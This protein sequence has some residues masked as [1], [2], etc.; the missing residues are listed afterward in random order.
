M[1]NTK[2]LHGYAYNAAGTPLTGLT[3]NVYRVDTG[4]LVASTTTLAENLPDYGAG[5][6]RV[7]NLA[8]EYR[9]RAEIVLNGSQKL[10]RHDWSGEVDHLT[11]AEALYMPARESVYLNGTLIGSTFLPLT[12]GTISGPVTI[13]SNLA[14]S[15]SVTAGG[16]AVIH[17]GNIGSQ[18][19]NYAATAGNADTVD[20][21]HASA[22][23]L[24]GHSHNNVVFFE[25]LG[26]G[27]A[28]WVDTGLGA[29]PR[30]VKIMIVGS[31]MLE[32]TMMRNSA[33]DVFNTIVH[34]AT[35]PYHEQ[36]SS[37]A[38]IVGTGGNIY[39]EAT[40]NGLHPNV[41]GTYYMGMA[42]R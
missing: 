41:N 15:G 7:D 30:L 13:N 23:A 32:W 29:V 31:S 16:N 14:V 25:Y 10:V 39:L 36:V 38:R 21:S 33:G 27:A 24:A 40:T 6:W 4:A 3:V 9:H 17:T 8:T 11:V 12:G 42:F 34:H 35:A 18:S 28:R 20:G 1:P 37:H 2:R 22:F 26:N 19:V 5:Y